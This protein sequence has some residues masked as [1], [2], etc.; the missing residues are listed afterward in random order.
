[1]SGFDR[2]STR[3]NY[4]GG[5]SADC[6]LNKGKLKSNKYG[7]GNKHVIH[8]NIHFDMEFAFMAKYLF[9][10]KVDKEQAVPT[11]DEIAAI[12]LHEIGHML[13][14]VE[15]SFDIFATANRVRESIHGIDIKKMRDDP[16]A[17]DNFIN[18]HKK[19]LNRIKKITVLLPNTQQNKKL[20][21]HLKLMT[22]AVEKLNLLKVTTN[23]DIVRSSIIVNNIVMSDL[24]DKTIETEY[25]SRMIS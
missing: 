6:R 25:N 20:S 1:M 11:A 10:D 2:M 4:L 7:K 12:M 21:S 22:D 8:V 17:I 18:E 16:K 14:L 19:V 23:S 15:H 13:T 24:T 9:A 3:I 5:K